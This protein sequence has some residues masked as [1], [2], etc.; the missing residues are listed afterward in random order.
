M[1][2][3]GV[4]YC[5]YVERSTRRAWGGRKP[6]I[7]EHW[8]KTRSELPLY[9]VQYRREEEDGGDRGEFGDPGSAERAVDVTL[10]PLV[11]G[12]VPV[13]PEVLRCAR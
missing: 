7:R 2:V 8:S 9:L 5:H 3:M 6:V 10:E 4:R 11:H 1:M 13:G 12:N